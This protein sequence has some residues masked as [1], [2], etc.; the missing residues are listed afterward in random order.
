MSSINCIHINS[1][2]TFITFLNLEYRQPT[3][4]IF[5]SSTSLASSHSMEFPSFIKS[6]YYCNNIQYRVVELGS[7]NKIRTCHLSLIR[8]AIYQLIYSTML[9]GRVG[10]EPTLFLMCRFYRPVSSPTRRTYRNI[11]HILYYMFMK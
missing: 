5:E 7:A 6:T 3:V 2:A 10:V 1:P 9:V 8:R 4:L 11:I